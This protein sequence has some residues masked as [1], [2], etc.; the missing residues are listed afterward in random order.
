MQQVCV[1]E[2]SDIIMLVI[3]VVFGIVSVVFIVDGWRD[4]V[5]RER[6]RQRRTDKEPK[7]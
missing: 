3:V 4:D 2:P 7:S 6:A 1:S 5:K